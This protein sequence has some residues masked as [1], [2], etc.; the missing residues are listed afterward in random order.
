MTVA[1]TEGRF[2]GVS[3]DSRTIGAEQ[4]FVALKG[5]VHDGHRYIGDAVSRGA[6]GVL[7]QRDHPA[8]DDVEL[9]VP[10]VTVDDPHRALIALARSY[11]EQMNATIVGITGSNGKTTTKEFVSAMLSATGV[12]VYKSPGNFNNL[13]GLPLSILSMPDTVRFGVFELGISTPGEMSRLAPVLTPEV[14]AITNVGPTHLEFLGTVEGVARAKLELVEAAKAD[15]PVIVNADDPVLMREAIK[16]RKD[17]ITFGFESEAQYHPDSVE[18]GLDGIQRVSIEGHEFMLPLFGRHQVYNLL[19]AWA[20]VR[21]V[22]VG[23][24]DTATLDIQLDSAPMRGERSVVHGVTVISDCYNANPDSIDSVLDSL[25]AMNAGNSLVIVLGDMLELGAESKVFHRRAGEKLASVAFRYAALVGPHSRNMLDGAIGA[26]VST[27]RIA[28][29]TDAES[30]AEALVSMLKPG[31][32]LFVKG[33]RGIALEKILTV[34][35]E[36]GGVD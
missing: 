29:F 5:E 31:D 1:S 25:A 4:L 21:T 30:C 32:T 12:S 8:L 13:F 15:V 3:I 6:A 23:L 10:V 11:R 34:W 7:A 22:G 27:E 2:R 9:S 17:L 18:I 36:R 24:A 26:G 16:V 28:H 14:I 19:A 33:S 35:T 20:I